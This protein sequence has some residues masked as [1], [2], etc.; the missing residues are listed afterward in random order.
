VSYNV[1]PVFI[2]GSV[3]VSDVAKPY[4]AN[5]VGREVTVVVF[6]SCGFPSYPRRR[7]PVR[8]RVE[9]FLGEA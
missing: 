1:P 2:T 7:V 3:I 5:Y 8:L 4:W 9:D 6:Y